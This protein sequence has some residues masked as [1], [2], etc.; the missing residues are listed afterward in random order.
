LTW[1]HHLHQKY[2]KNQCHPL[3]PYSIQEGLKQ[4]IR[5]VIISLS[6]QFQYEQLVLFS[7][8]KPQRNPFKC[9]ISKRLQENNCSWLAR[10]DITGKHGCI[11]I[12]LPNNVYSAYYIYIYIRWL[13]SWVVSVLESGTEGPGFK[14]QPRRCRVTVLGKLF[15]TIVPLFTEQRNWKQPS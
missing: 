14:S 13:S 10:A 15:T 9:Q 12:T 8:R 3:Q 7:T 1:R 6:Q 5:N 4:R 2:Q 11:Q